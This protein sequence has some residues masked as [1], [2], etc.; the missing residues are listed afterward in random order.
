M[1]S[2]ASIILHGGGKSVRILIVFFR[3]LAGIT[4]L[5]NAKC[6]YSNHFSL[7]LVFRSLILPSDYA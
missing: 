2:F 5:S 7:T 4:G 1:S 3:A 6:D